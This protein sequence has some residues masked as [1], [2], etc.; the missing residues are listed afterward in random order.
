MERRLKG[1]SGRMTPSLMILRV[2]TIVWVMLTVINAQGVSYVRY[3]RTER[4]FIRGTSMPA[5]DRQGKEHLRVFYDREDRPVSKGRI[6]AAG[7]L[8]EEEVL[9]YDDTGTLSRRAVRDGNG[10]V[11]ALYVYGEGEPMSRA[12]IDHVYPDRNPKEFQDRV[13]L[14]RYGPEGRVLSYRFFSVDNV[15]WGAIEYDYFE[16]G[17]VKEERWMRGAHGK[18]VRLFQYDYDPGSRTYK[19]TEYDSSGSPR[20]RVAVALPEEKRT[21]PEEI[22][23]RRLP[24]EDRRVMESPDLIYLR[25]G[26]TLRVDILNVS[27]TYVRFSLFGEEQIL[28]MPLEKVGEIERRDGTILYPKLY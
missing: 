2:W 17:L 24:V 11:K 5:T 12:F 26:E 10:T 8:V 20:S 13:T 21:T 23:R 4:D 16:T 1:I 27:D 25:D 15:Q 18:T 9:Q 28:T 19:L 3:Y 14:I 22:I 6:D 7:N